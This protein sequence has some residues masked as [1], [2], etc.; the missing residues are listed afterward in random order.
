MS[1][2]YLKGIMNRDAKPL[3]DTPDVTLAPCPFCGGEAFIESIQDGKAVRC[4][5][6]LSHGPAEYFGPP[7]L[8]PARNRA[9]AA[10]NIR[11]ATALTAQAERIAE[12]E[13]FVKTAAG[14]A[15]RDTTLGKA[16]R[17]LL[18]GKTS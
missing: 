18:E 13:A 16:A 8:G 14:P 9:A 15:Y 11:A 12:L 5:K 17:A 6:C 2:E 1:D 4:G 3:D 10:W 7:S